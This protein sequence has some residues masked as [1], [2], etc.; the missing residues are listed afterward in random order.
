MQRYGVATTA[1]L[2]RVGAAFLDGRLLVAVRRSNGCVRFSCD[3][4]VPLVQGLGDLTRGALR[5]L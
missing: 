4:A 1:D 2:F 3:N 5:L